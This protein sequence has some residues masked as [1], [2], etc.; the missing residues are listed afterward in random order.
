MH[1]SIIDNEKKPNK[2][3]INTSKK[4]AKFVFERLSPNGNPI[5]IETVISRLV[6]T[7]CCSIFPTKY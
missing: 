2:L 3:I 4:A 6:V 1:A 7:V 5:S